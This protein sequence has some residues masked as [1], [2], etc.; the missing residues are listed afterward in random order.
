MAADVEAVRRLWSR[1][2]ARGG[3]DVYT[4]L[5]LYAD[6]LRAAHAANEPG[7]EVLVKNWWRADADGP[8]STELGEG[9]A[10]LLGARD[11]G[12][13]AW[14]SVGGECDERFELAV[15]A[16]IEGRTADLTKLL[17]DSPDL[18]T[19][20]S[21]YGHRATLL[22]YVA[23]NGVEIRRQVVPGNAAEV[24]ALLIATG[25]DPT[26][27]LSAYGGS[28]DVLQ[29]LRTSGHPRAAGVAGDLERELTRA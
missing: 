1:S 19:R 9:E 10:R 16:V 27:C 28:Y 15:E 17:A 8:L 24:A 18:V 3:E 5:S 13:D 11:H 21:A 26:A 20:R 12:F 7:A 22:H 14:S 6:A 4:Q 29:M 2:G 23:A 25:A